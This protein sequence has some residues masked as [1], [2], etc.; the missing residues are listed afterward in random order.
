ML[1]PIFLQR[2]RCLLSPGSMAGDGKSRKWDE[3]RYQQ[4]LPNSAPILPKEEEQ[5]LQWGCQCEGTRSQTELREVGFWGFCFFSISSQTF[6]QKYIQVTLSTKVTHK[7]SDTFSPKNSYFYTRHSLKKKALKNQNWIYFSPPPVCPVNWKK[8][9]ICSYS[10]TG[11]RNPTEHLWSWHFSLTSS[12]VQDPWFQWHLP[13]SAL[14]R[15]TYTTTARENYLPSWAV[16]INNSS[17]PLKCHVWP[18]LQ[19]GLVREEDRGINITLLA[20]AKE[21]LSAQL[22]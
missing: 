4:I 8:S 9:I 20:Y 16:S 14:T 19:K 18:S 12:S 1:I 3:W 15:N 21:T 5:S 17:N 22:S 6:Y 11:L 2:Q 7:S 13:V 10:A